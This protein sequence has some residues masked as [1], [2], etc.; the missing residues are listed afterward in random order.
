MLQLRRR[1]KPHA[2]QILIPFSQQTRL[3]ADHQRSG[4]SPVNQALRQA[5]A[6][7]RAWVSFTT[8][9]V[10][11]FALILRVRA[12][13]DVCTRRSS[14]ARNAARQSPTARPSGRSS[15]ELSTSSQ[16]AEYQL[17]SP[18]HSSR[19][20][21]TWQTFYPSRRRLRKTGEQHRYT[22]RSTRTRGRSRRDGGPK[23]SG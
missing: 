14:C 10:S 22:V 17:L 1:A 20:I 8:Y 11:M 21:R 3:M 2:A 19:Y 16:H 4:A 7:L 12:S 5:W 18:C 13:G 6:H 23:T 9:G 15:T